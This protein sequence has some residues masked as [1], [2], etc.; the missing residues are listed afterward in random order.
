[1][2]GIFKRVRESMRR[3]VTACIQENGEHF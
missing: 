3:H 2:G 1:T